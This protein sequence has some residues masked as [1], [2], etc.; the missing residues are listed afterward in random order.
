LLKRFI[1]DIF[2]PYH[3]ENKLHFNEVMSTFY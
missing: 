1:S 2:Q 3:I